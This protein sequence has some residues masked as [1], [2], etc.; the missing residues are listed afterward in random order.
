MTNLRDTRLHRALEQAPDATLR[1]RQHTREAIR[2]AAHGAVRPWWQRWL[3]VGRGRRWAPAFATV[4]VAGLITV[5][6]QA[7]EVPGPRQEPGAAD[8]AM[9]ASARPVAPP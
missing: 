4:L 1:P 5:L 9:P 6:W 2:G 3:P 7:Q 8:R